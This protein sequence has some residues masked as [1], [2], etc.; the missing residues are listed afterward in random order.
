LR[1]RYRPPLTASDPYCFIALSLYCLIA[2]LLYCF[3]ALLND[4]NLLLLGLNIRE[5]ELHVKPKTPQEMGC[6]FKWP[7]ANSVETCNI[8]LLPKE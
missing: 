2:L 5:T 4:K 8:E 1:H 6:I 3:I 7:G